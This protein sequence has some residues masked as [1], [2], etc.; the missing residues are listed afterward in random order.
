MAVVPRSTLWAAA[1]SGCRVVVIAGV[2][3]HGG[4][5]VLAFATFRI[6]IAARRERRSQTAMG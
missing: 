1:S 2:P 5:A 3:L 4:W 6:E